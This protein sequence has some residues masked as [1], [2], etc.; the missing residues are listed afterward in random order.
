M[1]INCTKRV[2]LK[3]VKERKIIFVHSEP[4]RVLNFFL[5]LRYTKRLSVCVEVYYIEDVL[6]KIFDELLRG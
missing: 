4:E 3:N 1:N 5:E 2:Y 6:D